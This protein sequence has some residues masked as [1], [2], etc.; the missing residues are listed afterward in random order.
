M[1]KKRIKLQE[2]KFYKNKNYREV[3]GKYSSQRIEAVF[4]ATQYKHLINMYMLSLLFFSSI[5]NVT[6]L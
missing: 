5:I 6:N 4:Y 3:A 2:G 1:T